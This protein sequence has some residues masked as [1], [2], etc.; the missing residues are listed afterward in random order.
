MNLGY[1]ELMD[2]ISVIQNNLEDIVHKHP[3]A[4]DELKAIIDDAQYSLSSAYDIVS[5]QWIDS[6]EDY[7]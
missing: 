2:R 3:K 7:E 1:Y 6:C 4:S 5:D